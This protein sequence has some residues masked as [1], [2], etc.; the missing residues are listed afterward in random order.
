M[1][2]QLIAAY[3]MLYTISSFAS[4][5]VPRTQGLGTSGAQF[6]T[7]MLRL[8]NL[9]HKK[10]VEKNKNYPKLSQKE[11]DE[12]VKT[13]NLEIKENLARIAQEEKQNPITP[14]MKY[15]M[16]TPK[17]KKTIETNSEKNNNSPKTSQ[18]EVDEWLKTKTIEIEK[19]QAKSTR[20]KRLECQQHGRIYPHSKKHK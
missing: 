18:S 10:E 12:W 15:S 5:H 17:H 2:L 20:T 16:H 11:L 19:K 6:L 9:A 8:E 3:F 7:E 14:P 1:K 4:Q 13:T